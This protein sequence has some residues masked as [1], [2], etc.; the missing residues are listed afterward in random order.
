MIPNVPI[1]R[2]EYFDK[3][4]IK[5]YNIAVYVVWWW[6]CRETQAPVIPTFSGHITTM[7]TTQ[8]TRFGALLA[9]FLADIV[10]K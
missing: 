6:R 7:K 8:N 2:Q 5:R 9:H 1:V 10:I 3:N 4:H